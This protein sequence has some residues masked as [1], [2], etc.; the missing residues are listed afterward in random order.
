MTYSMQRRPVVPYRASYYND[1]FCCDGYPPTREW[2]PADLFDG[3]YSAD[4]LCCEAGVRHITCFDGEYDAD[5]PPD[6]VEDVHVVDE[7]TWF[8]LNCVLHPEDY[9][10]N[11]G[12]AAKKIGGDRWGA[13]GIQNE[14]PFE[15]VVGAIRDTLTL[16]IKRLFASMKYQVVVESLQLPPLMPDMLPGMT[17]KGEA[18][19]AFKVKLLAKDGQ[20]ANT[21]KVCGV[22]VPCCSH[23]ETHE[24]ALAEKARRFARTMPANLAIEARQNNLIV[25]VY[26]EDAHGEHGALLGYGWPRQV[27]DALGHRY[28]FGPSVP[29]P[30]PHIGFVQA[31]AMKAY[32]DKWPP[33]EQKTLT[34]PGKGT[35]PSAYSRTFPYASKEKVIAT[36]QAA[37]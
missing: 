18:V 12:H 13:M 2:T 16:H 35:S 34:A 14:I 20:L 10:Q 27:C 36:D 19:I 3:Y 31:Q 17:H 24:A 8:F 22:I 21:T 28:G 37:L 26:G 29:L 11:S 23:H 33:I 7:M 25:K 30:H 6:Y 1:D 9:Q 5:Y 15:D 32:Q 4:D